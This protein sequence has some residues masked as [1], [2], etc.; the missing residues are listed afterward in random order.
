MC[1]YLSVDRVACGFLKEFRVC[2]K[3]K[4][5][6]GNTSLDGKLLSRSNFQQFSFAPRSAS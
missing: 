6:K 4:P 2:F 3:M 1:D 5:E